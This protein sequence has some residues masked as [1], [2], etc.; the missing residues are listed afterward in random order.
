MGYHPA[1]MRPRGLPAAFGVVVLARPDGPRAHAGAAAGQAAAV[2]DARRPLQAPQPRAGGSGRHGVGQERGGFEV[3]TRSRATSR[4]PRRSTCRSSRPSTSHQ[5]DGLMMMTNGNLPFTDAQKQ[6]HRRLRP[7][8]QGAHRRALRDADL[9]Q[10]PGVRRDAG[11]LLPAVAHPDRNGH[12]EGRGAQGRGP[13]PPG[14]EDARLDA[15]R[16]STSSTSSARHRGTPRR[17]TE[18]ISQVGRFRTDPDGLLARPRARAA[19]PRHRAHGHVGS[20]EPS[21]GGDYP[22]AWTRDFGKGRTFYTA[23]GHRDDIWAQRRGVPRAR[24]RRHSLGARARELADAPRLACAC[25]RS[26]AAVV[27]WI[28]PA[29]VAQAPPLPAPEFHHLHLNSV[30]PEAAIDFYTQA[31]PA[32]SKDTFAGQPALK[33]P[34]NVLGPVQQ[35]RH[36]AGHAAA[37][38]VLALR[39][40]RHRRARD[41]RALPAAERHAAA[42]LHGGEG[43]AHGVRQ[44]RHLSGIGGVLGLDQGADRRGQGQ[45]REAGGR[46]AASPTCADRTMR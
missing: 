1:R 6:A 46:R 42:A 36:A 26:R 18:N 28:G 9:L 24:H 32:T 44:Q 23:L 27:A 39:L 25:R 29:V 10:L 37:D 4:T 38:G 21:R 31:V 17:P 11:R 8:R 43:A 3:T 13:K 15:G 33:S 45:R 7:R 5:F 16:S 22:Q 20:A 19:Q 34:N 41:A 35:G 40:A 2:P 12:A 14:H 30:N